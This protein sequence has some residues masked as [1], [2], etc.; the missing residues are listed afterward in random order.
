MA[1][2]AAKKILIATVIITAVSVT[3]YL[4]YAYNKKKQEEARQTLP[5]INPQDAISIGA[6]IASFISGL[7]GAKKAPA[8]TTVSGSGNYESYG[9]DDTVY[10]PN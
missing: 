2:S 6:G 9:I 1:A 7:F 8:T 5:K 4:I 10:P 3:G